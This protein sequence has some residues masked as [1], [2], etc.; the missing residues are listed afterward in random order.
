MQ[1]TEKRPIGQF[2]AL[3]DDGRTY[4]VIEWRAFTR[5]LFNDNTW[6]NEV[7]GFAHLHFEAVLQST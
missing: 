5:T 3:G 4:T 7:A 1:T 2:T 6:S